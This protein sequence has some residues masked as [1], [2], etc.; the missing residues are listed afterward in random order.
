MS[1]SLRFRVGLFTLLFPVFLIATGLVLH[2]A[3]QRSLERAHVERLSAYIYNLLA[4]AEMGDAGLWLPLELSEERFN[5]VQSGLI[6]VVRDARENVIW[7]SVSAL[8]VD[9]EDKNISFPGELGKFD[10]GWTAG[11]RYMRVALAVSFSGAE[12]APV[13]LFEVFQEGR[14]IKQEASTF[15]AALTFGLFVVA[16]ILLILTS[17]LMYWLLRPLHRVTDELHQVERG[18]LEAISE[19]YPKELS[20]LT[21]ALNTVVSAERKQRERYRHSL[22]DLAHSLKTPLAVIRG[23]IESLPGE[24]GPWANAV[25]QQLT[26]MDEVLTY[27]L[28][29][30]SSAGDRVWAKPVAIHD[31][32]LRLLE[33]L[34]RVYKSRGVVLESAIAT[35]AGFLGEQADFMEIAGNLIENAFK[36]SD[37]TVAVRVS[38]SNE[39]LELVIADDGPGIPANKWRIVQ[40]RGVRL[41]SRPIG[42]GI[43]LAVAAELVASYAGD[44]SLL[45]S[46]TDL[47]GANISVRLPGRKLNN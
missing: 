41:D 19:S 8:G 18:E 35:D 2:F 46:E 24:G 6:A 22:E 23:E 45:T 10:A 39:H 47:P 31:C 33:A 34:T 20:L 17:V 4:V 14:L 16:G 12:S 29:R 27:Q 30:A 11:R 37:T 26:R 38:C 5:Q 9:P 15:T 44:L 43:G 36:Y 7:S 13:Y 40:R 21:R 1:L 32:L 42:Q 3:N 28:K 25:Q